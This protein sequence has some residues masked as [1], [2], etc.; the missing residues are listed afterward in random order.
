MVF[1]IPS[2]RKA[3]QQNRTSTPNPERRCPNKSRGTGCGAIPPS[4]RAGPWNGTIQ[5]GRSLATVCETKTTIGFGVVQAEAWAC[6]LCSEARL[7][8]LPARTLPDIQNRSPK[9]LSRVL[10]QVMYELGEGVACLEQ[11]R[12]GLH[13]TAVLHGVH[14]SLLINLSS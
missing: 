3:C 2:R 4:C 1:W 12:F 7:Q 5:F 14:G 9:H 8:K 11:F 13:V 6:V 10:L